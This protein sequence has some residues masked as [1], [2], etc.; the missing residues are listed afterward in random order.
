MSTTRAALAGLLATYDKC[1]FDGCE[2][3]GVWQGWIE[4]VGMGWYCSDHL[5]HFDDN[6]AKAHWKEAV[7][8]A[9]LALATVPPCCSQCGGP[10]MPLV[11]KHCADAVDDYD[12]P[13]ADM[14][15][16]KVI[17][18]CDTIEAA[19]ANAAQPTGGMQVTYFGDFAQLPPSARIRLRWWARE[20]R[21]ALGATVV[22]K[23]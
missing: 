3:R 18:L 2:K 9:E 8:A 7:E 16:A 15:R 4:P 22:R 20:L 17:A 13:S 21:E 14:L 10:P 19:D 12:A 11:C 6:A 23:P 1:H 5:E